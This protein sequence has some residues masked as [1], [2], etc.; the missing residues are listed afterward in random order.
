MSGDGSCEALTIVAGPAATRKTASATR[1]ATFL[2]AVQKIYA[3]AVDDEDWSTA[4]DTMATLFGAVGVSFEVFD[5]QTHEPIF[6]E[7]GS[8]LRLVSAQEYVDYYGRISPRVG[9]NIGR[10]SGFI[11][12]DHMILTESEMDR[13]EFYQD[14]IRPVGL[15]YFLAAQV[16]CTANHQAVFAVQRSPSQ[17]HVGD[18]EIDML[19]RLLPHLQQAMDLRFRLAAEQLKRGYGFEGLERLN[20]GCAIVDRSGEVLHANRL[21]TQIVAQNDGIG[22][23]NDQ[24]SFADGSAARRHRRAL[25]S[26]TQVEGQPIDTAAR[27]FPARRTNG[28]PPYLVAVRTVTQTDERAC[29]AWPAAALVFVRDPDR[30]AGLDTRLLSHSYGLSPAESGLA[31]ALDRGSTLREI[32]EERAVSITT[33]RSQL[34][35]LMAKLGVNRQ[36]DLIRVFANYR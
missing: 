9:F 24:F 28:K 34:Y 13:D 11:S 23:R 8:N 3:S 1:E 7:L 33:V 5:K 17:G 16:F 18:A 12:Y 25:A 21:L 27:N 2:D 4:L 32:A 31:A 10:P 19:K 36:I 35:A 30:Y 14:C 6:I 15:R 26:L 20:E 22:L 29:F